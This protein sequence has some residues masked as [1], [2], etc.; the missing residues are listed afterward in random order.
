MLVNLREALDVLSRR[1]AAKNEWFRHNRIMGRQLPIRFVLN[2][3][4]AWKAMG[5]FRAGRTPFRVGVPFHKF[6]KGFG[7]AL[8]RMLAG[9]K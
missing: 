3:L 8:A 5:G 9:D 1:R 6:G 7:A 4:L 2:Q